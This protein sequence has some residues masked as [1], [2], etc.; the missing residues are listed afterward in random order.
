MELTI[1]RQ[2]KVHATEA[3]VTIPL[4]K[5]GAP[6]I[7]VEVDMHPTGEIRRRVAVVAQQMLGITRTDDSRVQHGNSGHMR[8]AAAVRKDTLAD[9]QSRQ[10]HNEHQVMSRPTE[11]AREPTTT[12]IVVG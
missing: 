12:K 11:F 1:L 7:V 10:R 8:L 9:E 5:S 2:N 6:K 4:W 3:V